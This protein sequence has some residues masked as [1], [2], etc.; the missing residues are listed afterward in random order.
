MKAYEKR[1]EDKITKLKNQRDKIECALMKRRKLFDGITTSLNCSVC[2]RFST[3]IINIDMK[4]TM[5]QD[6]LKN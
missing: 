5:L 3:Q 2:K 4:L 1:D 6:S